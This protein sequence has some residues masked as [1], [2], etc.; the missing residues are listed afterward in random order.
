MKKYIP[1]IALVF[2]SSIAFVQERFTPVLSDSHKK[3]IW[4]VESDVVVDEN[5]TDTRGDKITVKRFSLKGGYTLLLR[6]VV[7]TYKEPGLSSQVYL[8]NDGKLRLIADSDGGSASIHPEKYMYRYCNID[9]DDYFI[10]TI[11][12]GAYTNYLY[13]KKSGRVI[14]EFDSSNPACD[15]KNNLLVYWDEQAQAVYLFDLATMKKYPLDSFLDEEIQKNGYWSVCAGW[16]YDAF[17]IIAADSQKVK[18]RFY[19]C[20]KPILDKNGELVDSEEKSIYFE[21]KK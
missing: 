10:L 4:E 15:T 7:W 17:E 14:L 21:V 12:G 16:V 8:Q 11:Y 5:I 20:Y 2:L 19:G 6:P 18:L 9:F 13:E 1:A 3:T